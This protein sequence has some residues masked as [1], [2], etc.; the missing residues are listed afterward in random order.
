MPG[1]YKKIFASFYDSF[2]HKTERGLYKKRKA[3]IEPLRGKVLEVGSGTGINYQFYSFDTQLFA[4]D[5][6]QHM[7][8]KAELKAHEKL[9]ITYLNFGICDNDVSNHIEPNSLDAI[10]STLVLCSVSNPELALARFKQWLK[11]DG[12]LIVLEHIHAENPI[13]KILQNMIN[14]LW[15]PVADGCNIN[16][17]TDQLLLHAGFD[18]TDSVYFVQSLRWVMG[19]YRIT[20]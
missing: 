9:N 11:P 19:V 2:M 1:L 18:S 13:N 4:L 6:N 10:V 20:T 12:K 3:L 16:R 14:P 5:P 8:S 15:R 7:L 17:N